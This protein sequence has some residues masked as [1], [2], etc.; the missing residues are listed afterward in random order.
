MDIIVIG[1][2]AWG[3]PAAT[4]L[5]ER[6][7]RV[8]LLDRWGVG[9]PLA[10]SFGA[11]RIWR[12]SDHR[13]GRVALS[14]ASVEALERASAAAGEAVFLRRGMLWRDA[15]S[16]RDVAR[17]LAE[18]HIPFT[19]VDAADVGRFF[20]GLRPNGNG[21]VWSQ[22]AGVVLADRSL[23]AEHRRFLAAGGT[24]LLGK[25]AVEL[26]PD[27]THPGVRCDDGSV[28]TADLVV[29]AAGPGLKEL[30]DPLLSSPLPLQTR[31]EQVA[32]FGTPQTLAETDAYPTLY[33]GPSET[34][35]H[36]YA[37]PTPGIGYK[38][39]LGEPIRMWRPG[40][41]DRTPSAE[42]TQL[43]RDRVARDL[44]GVVPELIDAQVCT[45]T[46]TPDEEFII[47]RLPGRILIAGG[48]SGEGF[49]F[50]SLMGEILA[51]LA[52]DRP[53]AVNLDA[54]RVT[55]FASAA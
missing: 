42:R 1:A 23:H 39:G 44:T 33:D 25:T 12:L 10:S 22:T 32:H 18:H 29:V 28:L 13:P 45:Y 52:E 11:S 36:I 8:R 51:D 19:E 14:L 43:L 4:R 31:L 55:R 54:F 49:K 37:M 5:A 34:E 30:V 24:F 35:S 27:E 17:S 48:D 41:T 47:D 20:P 7:H 50:T 9:N 46:M 40:D 2:G 6:G 38:I 16:G 21:A 3:Q 53:P 26:I 15:N